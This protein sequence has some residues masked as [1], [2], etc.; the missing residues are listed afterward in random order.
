VLG[1][2]DNL[3]FLHIHSG[4]SSARLLRNSTVPGDVHV[5]REIYLEGPVPGNV[6]DEEFRKKRAEFLSSL[7]DTPDYDS[8]LRGANAR[9]DMLAKA[10]K[11]REVVIWVDYCMFCQTIMLHVIDE[12][13]KQNWPDTKLSLVYFDPNLVSLENLS[14]LMDSRYVVTQEEIDLAHNAWSA[15]TSDNPTDI[16]NIL[17]RDCSKLPYLRSAFARFLEQYPYVHNGLNRTQNQLLQVVNN[18]ATKLDQIFKAVTHDMEEE[19]FMGDTSLWAIIE[20]LAEAKVPLLTIS[21]PKLSELTKINPEAYESPSGKTLQQ[22]DVYVTDA[23]KKVLAGNQDFIKLN[24]ID[25]WLGGVHLQGPEAQWRWDESK[26]E[27]VKLK[28]NKSSC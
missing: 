14:G 3:R 6:S 22:W 24:G 28:S 4:D 17:K 10:G 25:C 15:F 7:M 27:L 5:W 1:R 23:G 11:Y 26:R 18:G 8:I 12:C 20:K 16:E 21:G 13:A 19:P 9:Y 2:I